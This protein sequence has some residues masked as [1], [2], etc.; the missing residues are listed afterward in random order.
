MDIV[1]RE[2]NLKADRNMAQM[3]RD[4]LET[5]DEIFIGADSDTIFRPDILHMVNELIGETD[6]VL[7]LYNSVLHKAI[8]ELNIENVPCLVKSYWSGRH[9]VRKRGYCRSC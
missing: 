3:Y 9:S 8:S 4:F 6:G 2:T 5:G 1:V 7:S